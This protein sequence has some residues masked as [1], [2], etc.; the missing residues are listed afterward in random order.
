MKLCLPEL[1]RVVYT[2]IQTFAITPLCL[3]ALKYIRV[4]TE[5]TKAIHSE[6][7]SKDDSPWMTV[8]CA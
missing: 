7:V 8:K 6:T 3:T 5:V 4:N 2:K 1:S